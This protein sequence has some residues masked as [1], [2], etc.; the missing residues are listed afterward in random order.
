MVDE[1]NSDEWLPTGEPGEHFV[2]SIRSGVRIAGVGSPSSSSEITLDLNETGRNTKLVGSTVA[3]VNDMGKN[4]Q[5]LGLGTVTEVI[6]HNRWHEDPTFRSARDEEGLLRGMSGDI[7][8]QRDAKIRVQASWS[9][10]NPDEAWIPGGTQLGMSPATGTGVHLVSGELVDDIIAK[11]DDVHYNGF[12]GGSDNIPLPLYI[13]DNATPQGAL[14]FGIFGRSGSGKA[15]ALDTP[16]PTPD[17]WK[18]IG[19]IIAGDTVYD[20][21]GNRCTVVQ[22][23]PILHN[24]VCYTVRFNDNSTIVACENH[25][26]AV[27]VDGQAELSIMST[28]EM[29]TQQNS[30]ASSVAGR[31]VSPRYSVPLTAPIVGGGNKPGD[32]ETAGFT[33]EE[34]FLIGESGWLFSP[35]VDRRDVGEMGV[36]GKILRGSADGR[37]SFLNGTVLHA[38][39]NDALVRLGTVVVCRGL[40]QRQAEFLYEIVASLGWMPT[41]VEEYGDADG[42]GFLVQWDSSVRG[43]MFGGARLVVSIEPAASVPVR[44]LTVDSPN[45]LYLAGKGFIPTHNTAAATYVIAGQMRH[46]KMGM[47]IVDPQGQWAAEHSL[48]FS[49]QGFAEELGREVTVARVS[50]DLR[51]KEDYGLFRELLDQ[52]TFYNQI[53]I[54]HPQ[55]QEIAGDEISSVLMNLEDWSDLDSSVLLRKV[56]EALGS[57][58]VSARIYT[59]DGKRERFVETITDIIANPKEFTNALRQFHPIANLFQEKNSW[60]KTRKPL[61]EQLQKVFGRKPGVPAPIL[62][63]D[64]SSRS[65]DAGEEISIETEAAYTILDNDAMKAAILRNL[66][67]T[68]K[69]ESEKKFRNNENLNTLIVLDEAWRYAAPLGRGH[70]DEKE[71]F[72][73]SKDL[74]G[75]ARD[76]RKFGISWFYISQSPRSINQD[77]WEQIHIF[78]FG[79]GLNGADLEKATEAYE[80]KQAALRLYKRFGNPIATGIWPF[81][82]QGPVSPL[83]SAN[84]PLVLNMYTDFDDFRRDNDSWI[85][86]HRDMLGKE[87]LTGVPA[88]PQQKTLKKGFERRAP[89]T[90]KDAVDIVRKAA[91][92]DKHSQ[93]V[94]VGDPEGFSDPLANF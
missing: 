49:V 58:T 56:L 76:T 94:G 25:L 73:L 10:T 2:E 20:E 54:K 22:A 34:S 30:N 14:H 21:Q 91:E 78:L 28:A 29:F 44:C 62:I 45:S 53:R 37:E 86:Q 6:T 9:R 5:E 64:M 16:I 18:N 38:E 77:I 40:S 50:E 17:G 74:A 8:D 90:S 55:T 59:T 88:P 85:R 43:G 75:Y 84:A 46:N 32:G 12:L 31:N 41:L 70:Q 89:K 65:P 82:L 61:W 33:V 71:I 92:H 19:D 24:Q 36:F 51:L 35:L 80:D 67:A 48:P 63:L 26:W 3:I 60:G 68:L 87:V 79:T 47:V 11:V 1:A 81:L 93:Q 57:D 7:G 39:Q 13:P 23:H 72:E 52:T 27:R 69:R 42:K 15:L 66:F 4:G 83:M